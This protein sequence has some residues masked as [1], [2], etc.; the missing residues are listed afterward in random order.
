MAGLPC[1]IHDHPIMRYVLAEEGI[2][3]DLSKP[4]GLA[5]VLINTLA[6]PN[7]H[8]ERAQ[9]RDSVRQRFDWE[10]LVPLYIEMF[11]R[12]LNG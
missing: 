4:G 9:R 11:R 10:V 2:F 12:C 8:Q 1:V 5:N 3:A 6:L 7:S